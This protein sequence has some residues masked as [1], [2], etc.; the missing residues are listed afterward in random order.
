MKSKVKHP[1]LK[2]RQVKELYIVQRI[3]DYASVP[4]HRGGFSPQAYM[5]GRG[6]FLWK[7]FDSAAAAAKFVLNNRDGGTQFGI[8]RW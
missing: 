7:E 4:N 6:G 5:G 2:E 8:S 3:D 1:F